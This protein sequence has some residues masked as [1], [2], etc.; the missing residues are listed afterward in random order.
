MY[1]ILAFFFFKLAEQPFVVYMIVFI[2][3]RMNGGITMIYV[4]N[5]DHL[6]TRTQS[7]DLKPLAYNSEIHTFSIRSPC[8]LVGGK[9]E[10]KETF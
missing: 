7:R 8:L 4:L 1:C 2:L 5:Q 10:S 3:Q 9:W 6:T